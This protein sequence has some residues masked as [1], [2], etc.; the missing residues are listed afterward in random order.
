MTVLCML[1]VGVL[2]FAQ[3]LVSTLWFPAAVLVAVLLIVLGVRLRR[4]WVYVSVSV[5]LFLASAVGS[6]WM[7]QLGWFLGA[8]GLLL[9]VAGVGW[10]RTRPESDETRAHPG[11]GLLCPGLALL[12]APFANVFLLMP[13]LRMHFT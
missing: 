1:A 4:A 10:A 13:F 8:A 3:L 12:A 9:V 7:L 11:V 6:I 2:I 5:L